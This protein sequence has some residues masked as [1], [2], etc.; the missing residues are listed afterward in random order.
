MFNWLQNHENLKII[1]KYALAVGNYLNGLTNRGGAS[2]VK[3]DMIDK[4]Q[5]FKGNESKKPLLVHI[6][7]WCEK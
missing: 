6:V 7:E 5:D 1:L 3:L 4:L 2:S